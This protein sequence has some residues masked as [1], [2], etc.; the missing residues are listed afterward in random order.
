[1][2]ADAQEAERRQRL[3]AK[4]IPSRD[5]REVAWPS[6]GEWSL[7]ILRTA[8]RCSPFRRSRECSPEVLLTSH[9]SGTGARGWRVCRRSTHARNAP[10]D[11]SRMV[12][13]EQ[14]PSLDGPSKTRVSANLG[15]QDWRGRSGCSAR[16]A[17]SGFGRA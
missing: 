5:H 14:H 9:G 10:V 3:A 2:V 7:P 15:K 13:L 11:V 4:P 12:S 6:A 16:P 8:C 1:M 17:V